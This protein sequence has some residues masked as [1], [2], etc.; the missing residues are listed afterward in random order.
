MISAVL[1]LQSMHIIHR[2]IKPENI[3]V[4]INEELKL[5]D[6]GWSIKSTS[7]KRTTFCGTPEYFCP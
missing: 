6:F 5:S 4:S 7:S 1:Y 2:D 3:L